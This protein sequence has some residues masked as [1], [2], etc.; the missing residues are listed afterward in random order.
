MA[1][2]S[3]VLDA[4]MKPI[5]LEG[6]PVERLRMRQL[7]AFFCEKQGLKAV[8]AREEYLPLFERRGFRRLA[9]DGSF[10][11]TSVNVMSVFESKGLEFSAVAVYDRD[12]TEN[13]KYIACTRALRELAIV[14]E[15]S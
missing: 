9:A 11:R 4:D 15:E 7:A 3:E 13:E 12:M 10:S 1:Y 14:E 8:I 2:V 6:A 5:G